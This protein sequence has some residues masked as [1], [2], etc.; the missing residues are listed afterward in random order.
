MNFHE[1]IQSED[2]DPKFRAAFAGITDE[3]WNEYVAG[4]KRTFGEDGDAD[5]IVRQ[6]GFIL[7]YSV[8]A[9]S[10]MEAEQ[11]ARYGFTAREKAQEFLRR[12]RVAVTPRPD[13]AANVE[14]LAMARAYI[15]EA[16]DGLD[17]MM[18][19]ALHR[20]ASF[21]S[22]G[23]TDRV[24]RATH[25][26][27]E[28]NMPG[29]S[30]WCA[31]WMRNNF[32]RL[33]VSHKLAAALCL[34]DV[35]DEVEVRAPWSAWSLVVPDGLFPQDMGVN[36]ER[37]GKLSRIW[38]MGAAPAFFV[39]R[40]GTIAGGGPR[41]WNMDKMHDTAF[42]QQVLGLIRGACLALSNPDDFAKEKQH[43]PS[44]RAASKP[45]RHGPPDLQ[46]ARFLL[47]APVKVDLRDHLAAALSG[48]KGASPT[49]QFLVRGHWR[50]Q[51]HGPKASLRKTIWIQP[52][53]KGPEE[54]RIL[55][56]QHRIE[57]ERA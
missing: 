52:F 44:A 2:V 13:S 45:S 27:S 22:R 54:S 21:L 16:T 23:L 42:G 55:L 14:T 18:V 51:A 37:L 43:G 40:S 10:K 36:G 3:Q 47:S 9:A 49:V 26:V 53:W 4:I 19:G 41:G 17:N 38:C 57:G 7:D 25:H 34:T 12:C 31:E 1:L 11:R 20:C 56:R 6:E 46:Q 32:A 29:V 15:S 24:G 50:N 8:E 48:R 30:A 28:E 33:E 5:P 35:P 39:V